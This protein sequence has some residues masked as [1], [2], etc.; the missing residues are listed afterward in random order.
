MLI[1]R[2]SR[3]RW[4]WVDDSGIRMDGLFLNL[5]HRHWSQLFYLCEGGRR[6]L[7][8]VIMLTAHSFNISVLTRVT[9]M[10]LLLCDWVLVWHSNNV[11]KFCLCNILVCRLCDCYN[12]LCLSVCVC[13][14]LCVYPVYWGQRSRGKW[15]LIRIQPVSLSTAQDLSSIQY[16][17]YII[18]LCVC[19]LLN[20]CLCMHA[21][22]VTHRTHNNVCLWCH[23]FVCRCLCL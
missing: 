9:S 23:G 4:T 20:A 11:L 14:R 8:F 18:S 15:E 22:F 10:S 17:E 1:H 19:A 13:L 2:R 6:T 7:L 16:Y 3:A 12:G 21:V 5:K